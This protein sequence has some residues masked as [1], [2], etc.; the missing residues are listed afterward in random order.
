ML[1]GLCSGVL[2]PQTHAPALREAFPGPSSFSTHVV[3]PVLDGQILPWASW[4]ARGF[5]RMRRIQ[6][7]VAQHYLAY[8][9]VTVIVLLACTMPW[10]RLLTRLY[11]R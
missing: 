9:L 2:R 8:I 3:D 10:G 11:A 4:V 7:G 1:V 5:I 6:G